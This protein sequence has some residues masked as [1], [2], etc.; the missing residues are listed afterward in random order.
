MISPTGE[1]DGLDNEDSLMCAVSYGGDR[2]TLEALLTGDAERGRLSE[3][4]AR[5]D[6]GDVDLLK[7]GHHGSEASLGEAEAEGLRAEVAV[8][9]AGE[10]NRYGHPSEEC[11]EALERAGSR[12]LCTKDVGDVTV[13]PGR[14]GVGVR[15]GRGALS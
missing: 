13:E 2:G 9:S 4:M 14:D 3:A 5:G 12:F 11:R 10:N 8:A 6:V 7:V 15:L 1:V